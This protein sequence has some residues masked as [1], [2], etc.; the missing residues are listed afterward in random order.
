MHRYAKWVSS[1]QS[2]QP[3]SL[4][5]AEREVRLI[6]AMRDQHSRVI[7]CQID[8]LAQRH[9]R[10]G[11]AL[12]GRGFKD[13][14]SLREVDRLGLSASQAEAVNRLVSMVEKYL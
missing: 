9:Q 1:L 7:S 4:P 6:M 3:S 8:E 13:S 12:A 14:Q 5:A 11:E 10:L 2:A